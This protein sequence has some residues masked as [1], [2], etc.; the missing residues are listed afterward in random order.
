MFSKLSGNTVLQKID[1]DA[2]SIP[3]PIMVTSDFN[4]L[5]FPIFVK[6]DVWVH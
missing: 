5:E 2:P 4:L 3:D 1:K 6:I